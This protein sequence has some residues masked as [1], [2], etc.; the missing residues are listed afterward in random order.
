MV[1]CWEPGV[2]E[3][4]VF[5]GGKM[6][7]STQTGLQESVVDLIMGAAGETTSVNKKDEWRRILHLGLPEIDD[8]LRVIPVG[9]IFVGD[10]IGGFRRR[11][12]GLDQVDTG[13]QQ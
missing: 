8:L 10:G 6:H 7:A 5:N 12:L 4:S 13:K 1:S 2:L 3:E 9:D 11:L